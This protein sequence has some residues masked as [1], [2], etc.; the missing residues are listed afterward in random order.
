[1]R[2]R[3]L[4]SQITPSPS[5]NTRARTRTAISVGR[6]NPGN[7]ATPETLCILELYVY[8]SDLKSDCQYVDFDGS[9]R[10]DIVAED[11]SA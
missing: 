3:Y 1:M 6:D 2:V 7:H 11:Q 5:L 10:P 9:M 8:I 4:N